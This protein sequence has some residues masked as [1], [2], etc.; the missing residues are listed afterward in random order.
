MK[1]KKKKLSRAEQAYR[2]YVESTVAQ[3][4]DKRP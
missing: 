3:I 4:E 2:D 1:L